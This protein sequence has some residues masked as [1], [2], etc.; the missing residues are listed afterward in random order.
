MRAFSTLE[1]VGKG[2]DPEFNFME[3]AKPFAAE[4]MTNG[5][6]SG[7]DDNGGLLG[8]LSRQAAQVGS[9]AFG[10]PRRLEDTLDKLEQGDVRVRVRSIETDRAL[11]RISNVS[12]GT[13]YVLLMGTFILSA[14]ILL[15]NQ[16]VWL[17]AI[18]ALIS[19]G[20]GIV[21]VRHLLR[22]DRYERMQ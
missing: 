9:S 14:T 2:L 5:N 15:V 16:F 18:A 11:R 3:V 22:I 4:L 1:G 19:L 8:E 20:L 17:A 21:L 12:M 6:L 10:L 13:N 7:R